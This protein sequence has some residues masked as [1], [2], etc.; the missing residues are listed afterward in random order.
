[1]I[2]VAK[3]VTRADIAALAGRKHENEI[4]GRNA[5][6]SYE[7]TTSFN[8]DTCIC[9]ICADITICGS[10]ETKGR[11]R[12]AAMGMA[13]ATT[14]ATGIGALAAPGKVGDAATKAI[15][16]SASAL[17]TGIAGMAGMTGMAA[18]PVIGWVALGAMT[19]KSAYMGLIGVRAQTME[20]SC[21]PEPTKCDDKQMPCKHVVPAAAQSSPIETLQD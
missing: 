18:V 10:T 4:T 1:M 16:G 3:T 11:I 12:N 6:M 14:V 20:F 19:I 21:E 7:M 8:P 15:T 2:P 13:A 5:S 17:G 9:Q